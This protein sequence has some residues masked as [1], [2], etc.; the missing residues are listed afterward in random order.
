[1]SSH[2][3]QY[4]SEVRA[5]RS[6]CRKVPYD[7]GNGGS[8]IMVT[9][10]KTLTISNVP[11]IN[12]KYY[13]QVRL[14]FRPRLASD[15]PTWKTTH[16]F[17]FNYFKPQYAQPIGMIGPRGKGL[18]MTFNLERYRAHVAPLKLNREQEDELLRDL[19]KITEALVDQSLSSPTYPLQLAIACQAFDALEQ[20]IALESNSLSSEEEAL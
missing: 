1:M 3:Q 5:A 12:R 8:V 2:P 7:A 11:D 4:G 13:L 14:N 15:K 9:H 10:S 18:F 6:D 17:L 19:W 20:A 16:V